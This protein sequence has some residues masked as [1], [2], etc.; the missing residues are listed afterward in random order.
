MG[1]GRHA[2]L[3][4]WK[5]LSIWGLFLLLHFS[6]ETF[7]TLLFKIIGEEGE[8]TFFH[9]KMLFVAYVAVSL[10]ELAVNRKHIASASGFVYSRALIAV[11]F[12]WLTI[13]LW[14]AAEA[15]GIRLPVI[16]W[17]LVYANVMTVLGVYFALRLEEALD[18]VE[19][20]PALRVLIVLVFACAVLS[21]VSFSLHLPMPFFTTPTEIP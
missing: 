20:R 3:K 15:L 18:D 19:F 5:L 16:P 13:T 12:P 1:D 9:M 8:T 21:Y 10:I 14:F 2:R 11:A 4:W 7:P 17:E 6:Y